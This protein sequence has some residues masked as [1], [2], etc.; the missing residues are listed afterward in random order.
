MNGKTPATR[1][2]R[3]TLRHLLITVAYVAVLSAGLK[4][5]TAYP[6]SEAG[7]A[8]AR[9]LLFT[10]PWVLGGLIWAFDRPGP[11]RDWTAA[12]LLFS[13]YPAATLFVDVSVALRA[14]ET[15]TYPRLG[16]LALFNVFMVIS[17]V[18]F[19]LKM[20]WLDCPTCATR[21]LL[22]LV[23]LTGQSRRVDNTRWCSTCHGLFWR[24]R[25]GVWRPERRTTWADAPRPVS[26][27][28]DSAISPANQPTG[29]LPLTQTS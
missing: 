20:R 21:T 23:R 12:T 28:D 16:S 5:V 14:A 13:F 26:L 9:W 6:A 15:A 2:L 8:A 25:L 24:D 27:S 11:Q 18:V 17:T 22:P 3:L 7:Y 19:Y 10:T 4:S 29:D 1:G